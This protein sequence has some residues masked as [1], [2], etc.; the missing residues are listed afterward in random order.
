MFSMSNIFFHGSDNLETLLLDVHNIFDVLKV[1]FKYLFKE[2]KKNGKFRISCASWRILFS[3]FDQE[4]LIEDVFSG[5]KLHNLQP[6]KASSTFDFAI[7][8]DFYKQWG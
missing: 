1:F 6:E 5:H 3:V 7:H 4:I 8:L 2:V